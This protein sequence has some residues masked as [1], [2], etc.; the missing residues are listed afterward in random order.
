MNV[1]MSK[2]K[3][4]DIVHINEPI[5]IES[6]ITD[7]FGLDLFKISYPNAISIYEIQYPHW[8]FFYIPSQHSFDR[9]TSIPS[10][11]PISNINYYTNKFN[12]KSIYFVEYESNEHS[13]LLNFKSSNLYSVRTANTLLFQF[14]YLIDFINS[15]I[16]QSDQPAWRYSK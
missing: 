14:Y 15:Q 5:T 16:K 10:I 4:K 8:Y 12:A 11:Q 2:I 9:R 7:S 3:L 1:R 13:F 6:I